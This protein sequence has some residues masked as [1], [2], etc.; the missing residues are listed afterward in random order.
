MKK[1]FRKKI[2]VNKEGNFVWAYL[3]KDIKDMREFYKKVSPN[4]TGHDNVVG[5]CINRELFNVGKSGKM[6][7]KNKILQTGFVLTCLDFVGESVVTH[8]IMHAVLFADGVSKVKFKK[9]YPIIIKD[10]V[11]E[12][13]LLYAFT[14]AV[15]DYYLWYYRLKDKKLI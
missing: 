9:Q 5:V 2:K 11:D 6:T 10:M 13:R 3:F 7:L 14:E 8:E 4:D 12:E 15:N 1:Y